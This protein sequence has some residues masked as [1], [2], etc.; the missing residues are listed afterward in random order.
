MG[1][2]IALI[3]LAIIF[4]AVGLFVVKWALIIG[5]VLLVAGIVMGFMSRGS[6][7]RL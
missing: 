7:T 5:L 6:R 1:I 4:G 2:V 3:V